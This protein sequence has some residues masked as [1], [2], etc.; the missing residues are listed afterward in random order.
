M[1]RREV[2]HE[3]KA[4]LL[5]L[6]AAGPALLVALVLLWTGDHTPKVEW[7]LTVVMLG[8]W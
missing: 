7:T 8:A 6:L 4:V 3:G 2:S 1:K 5:A